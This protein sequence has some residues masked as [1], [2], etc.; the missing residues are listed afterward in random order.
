MGY[1]IDIKAEYE[2]LIRTH[3]TPSRRSLNESVDN[4]KQKAGETYSGLKRTVQ[5][6][7]ILSIIISVM[8]FGLLILCCYLRRKYSRSA[9]VVSKREY[10]KI[11][12][13]RQEN[14]R[15]MSERRAM[16]ARE[17]HRPLRSRNGESR[18]NEYNSPMKGNDRKMRGKQRTNV[19]D[20]SLEHNSSMETTGTVL[21]NEEINFVDV[22]SGQGFEIEGASPI[23][24]NP[25][26]EDFHHVGDAQDDL[27]LDK[28]TAETSPTK[29]K[30]S[31][32]SKKKKGG[33]N[34][35]Y[36]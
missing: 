2:H 35:S 6:N 34:D 25:N 14:E 29:G 26:N 19:N 4:A 7:M 16:D 5:D 3:G 30:K 10:R 9:Q 24:S 23:K 15:Q 27:D 17:S 21:S 1:S 28:D 12:K 8:V 18:T 36:V 22:E 31:F 33:Q 20:P 32:F 13:N 11:V